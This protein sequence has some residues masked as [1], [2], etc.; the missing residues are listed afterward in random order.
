M[1][2][3]DL[4]AIIYLITHYVACNDEYCGAFFLLA[5]PYLPKPIVQE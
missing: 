5:V 1:S 4:K 2:T 3:P